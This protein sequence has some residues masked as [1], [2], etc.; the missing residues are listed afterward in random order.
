MNS[1]IRSR[2][3]RSAE[4]E[5]KGVAPGTNWLHGCVPGTGRSLIAPLFDVRVMRLCK[6]SPVSICW[7][8]LFFHCPVDS[9]RWETQC[10]PTTRSVY[11]N[12]FLTSTS[13]DG[14]YVLIQRISFPSML[15]SST[16]VSPG[17][18]TPIRSS[19]PVDG[20]LSPI[21]DKS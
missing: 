7:P 14:W 6:R 8:G 18:A 3:A 15:T 17:S 1:K 12:R 2:I 5:I 10:C 11:S 19:C 21:H 16:N 9:T 4:F 20:N 13:F